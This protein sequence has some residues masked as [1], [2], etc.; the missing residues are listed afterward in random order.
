MTAQSCIVPVNLFKSAPFSLFEG[1]HIFVRVSAVNDYGESV[2]SQVGD[3][4]V[5]LSR[6]D[7]PTN[8][9]ND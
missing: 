4:A 3:G 1:D 2:A 6:P 9:V 7:P 8:L 5:V